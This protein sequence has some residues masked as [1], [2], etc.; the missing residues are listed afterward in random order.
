L[1]YHAKKNK[2][3]E[4][5]L[6]R[7]FHFEVCPLWPR[8]TAG[9]RR[10]TFAKAYGMKLRCYWGFFQEHVRNMGTWR[11]YWEQRKNPS[12]PPPKLKRKKIKAL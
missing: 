2:T 5:P 6:N 8:Y 12:P 11:T 4:V 7:R 1:A 3:I 9:E 10:T